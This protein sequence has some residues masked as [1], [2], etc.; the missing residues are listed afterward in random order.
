MT[1]KIVRNRSRKLLWLPMRS[2]DYRNLP[3]GDVA[4]IPE[5]EM[6]GETPISKLI[7]AGLLCEVC[8]PE[9]KGG[10]GKPAKPGAKKKAG[11]KKKPGTKKPA[12]KKPGAGTRA[13]GKA[14]KR[15]TTKRA[16]APKG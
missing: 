7:R 1:D 4:R 6:T 10:R 9:K 11:T 16:K 5:S 2:G 3:A 8:D 12:A 14:K 13:K 15:A